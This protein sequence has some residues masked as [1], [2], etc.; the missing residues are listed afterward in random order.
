[1]PGH[2]PETPSRQD[3]GTLRRTLFRQVTRMLPDFWP[4]QIAPD[5]LLSGPG[6]TPVTFYERFCGRCCVVLFAPTRRQL[7]PFAA[8]AA[9]VPMLG[10]VPNS[11]EVDEPMD[12]GHTV[13]QDDGRIVQVFCGRARVEAPVAVVLRPTFAMEARLYQPTLADIE[14]ILGH[15]RPVTPQSCNGTAP[16]LLVPDV[17]PASLCGHLIAAHT[18]DHFESVMVR[19]TENGIAMVPDPG[20]KKRRDHRLTDPEL[21]EAVTEALRDRLLPA[22]ARA[23]HYSVTQMENYKVVAYDGATGGYFRPHRDNSTPD[24][25]HRRF[26][27][28]LNLNAGYAGGELVFPEFGAC[29]YRPPA[30]GA[31]V[32]SGTHL[33]AAQDVT[34]GRRYVLLTFLW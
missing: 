28:S 4:G 15:L 13:V 24:A 31:V 32:F 17:L 22:I 21:V 33:H 6:E 12:L 7:L 19:Q 29:R 20:T 14:D 26:A 30:G 34:A 18:A 2:H 10:I 27:L 3:A 16:V 9:R 5:F 1:M 23:F 11:E 25:R 8:L